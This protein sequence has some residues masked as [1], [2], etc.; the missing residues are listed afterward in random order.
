LLGPSQLKTCGSARERIV[1]KKS[2]M[3][4]FKEFV[5]ASTESNVPMTGREIAK[6][7]AKKK[8]K[9]SAVKRA[10]ASKTKAKKTTKK[11]TRPS[12]RMSKK[13]GKKAKR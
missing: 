2:F 5:E 13:A 12:K 7:K 1:A 3:D 4:K 11:S 8:A 10:T 9:E 6:T